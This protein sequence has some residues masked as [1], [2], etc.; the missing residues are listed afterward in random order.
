MIALAVGCFLV[1]DTMHR[2]RV[3]LDAMAEWWPWTL[4]ALALF[5]LLRSAVSVDSLIGP[6]VLAVAALC[7]LALSR[8]LDARAVQ[9]LAVPL[10]LA[11]SGAVLLVTAGERD[12]RTRWTRFLSTGRVQ[13]PAQGSELL[14]FRAVCGEL[15]ADLRALRSGGPAAVHVT[16]VAGHVRLIVP[17]S[18]QVR[19]HASGALLTRV[20]EIGRSDEKLA[21]APGFGE[22]HEVALHLLGVC[23]AI[24]IV[25]T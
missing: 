8:G 24:S 1:G 14:V 25:H 9:N 12:R 7:G 20:T 19:V 2:A 11:G 21:A 22:E 10:A 23:G 13:V 6:A 16:A 17:R 3:A 4:L 15:R 18:W 5:N